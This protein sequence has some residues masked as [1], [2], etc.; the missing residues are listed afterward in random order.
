MCEEDTVKLIKREINN[1]LYLKKQKQNKASQEA[2]FQ[3][4]FRHPKLQCSSVS[5]PSQTSASPLRYLHIKAT[6]FGLSKHVMLH[7]VNGGFPNV[8]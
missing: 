2:G 8:Q 5:S 6:Q 3:I 4:R 7:C 1:Q